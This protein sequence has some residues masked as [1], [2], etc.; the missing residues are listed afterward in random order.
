M[1]A[2]T[3]YT[4]GV[5]LTHKR[6][7]QSLKPGWT[8]NLFG[9]IAMH[10]IPAHVSPGQQEMHVLERSTSL[11]LSKRGRSVSLLF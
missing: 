4:P 6:W 11:S 9:L 10:L 7:T 8:D 2:L 1:S 5:F 3:R